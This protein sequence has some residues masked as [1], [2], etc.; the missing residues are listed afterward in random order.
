MWRRV[1]VLDPAA[2]EEDGAV[3]QHRGRVRERRA[4]HDEHVGR[5]EPVQRERGRVA[6]QLRVPLHVQALVG[7]LH[8]DTQF[9]YSGSPD[10]ARALRGNGRLPSTTQL[11]KMSEPQS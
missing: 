4:R 9:A 5:R 8:A 2:G 6:Q 3:A 7:E 1:A 11:R 10:L